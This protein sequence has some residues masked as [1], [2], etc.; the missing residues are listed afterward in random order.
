[1]PKKEKYLVDQKIPEDAEIDNKTAGCLSQTSTDIKKF[2]F[3][4]ILIM[5]QSETMVH[6]HSETILEMSMCL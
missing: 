6:K 2:K 1:M 4:L 3:F 5:E